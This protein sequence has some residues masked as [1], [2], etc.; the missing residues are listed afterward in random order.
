MNR[1]NN[2]LM[3]TVSLQ[4][5]EDRMKQL[6]DQKREKYNEQLYE[7]LL[8]RGKQGD[9]ITTEDKNKILGGKRRRTRRRRRHNKKRKSIRR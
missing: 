2:V 6:K 5:F 4:Q 8:A 7:L 9:E 1:P 3:D